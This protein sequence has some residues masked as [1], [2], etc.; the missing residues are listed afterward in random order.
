VSRQRRLK[1]G[2][3]RYR[4]PTPRKGGPLGI[5]WDEAAATAAT[6]FFPSY[7]RLTKDKWA[8]QVFE[9]PAWERD[10]IV[11]PAF[12]WKR[13]DG[14]RLYRRV[15]IWV[16]RKNGKTELLAGVAHLLLLGDA[17]HSA[18]CYSIASHGNQAEIVFDRAVQMAAYSPELSEQ[19]QPFSA[20]LW[21]EATS[22]IF[23]PLT[24][25][26]TGKHGLSTTYLLGDEVHEWPNDKLYTFVRQ[27]M[28]SREQPMEWLISTAGVEEG[29]GQELWDESLKICEGVFDDPETL[30]VIWCA[31]QDPKV[32][33]DIQDPAVWAE[34]NP[35]Y[36]VSPRADYLAK[37]AREAA[38]LA[39]RENDFKRYHLNIWVGAAERWISAPAWAAC[40]S[41][42]GRWKALEDELVGASCF[43]GNDLA[44]ARDMCARVLVFPPQGALERWTLLCRFWW[45][46]ANLKL[47]AAK[48]RV[49]VESWAKLG[50][51]TPTT[52][53]AADHDAIEAQIRADHEKFDVQKDGFDAWN[54]HMLAT[55][56]TDD[57]LP[58]ELVRFGI[59][60]MS[61]PSKH[62]ERLVLLGK[63]DHG[64]HPVLRWHVG[65]TTIRRDANDNY[66]PSK[67]HSKG[68]IDGVAA[69][70]IALAM[71]GEDPG[72]SYLD[73]QEL[74]VLP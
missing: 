20:S 67:G 59:A 26:P 22:S 9:L 71:A 25:K 11:R 23:R 42:E 16:P 54:A 43:A 60:S 6:A 33:I 19:Y 18:E 55:H 10:H 41:G 62:L 66:M 51:I 34:A 24:G 30:V 52:G 1:P 69:A 46:D 35:N 31:D 27:G 49:P 58:I 8:G 21:L 64:S 28:G 15:M 74:V 73:T 47:F 4:S 5:W 32:E 44:S 2:E 29:Y 57:G 13:A 37:M 7:C 40:T 61:A 72:R 17:V 45:P 56:L 3:P 50:A 63:L 14:T 36:P 39:S 12:G 65:N 53:N 70:V 48:S 38:Q 68:K